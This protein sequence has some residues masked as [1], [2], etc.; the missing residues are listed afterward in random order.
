MVPKCLRTGNVQR[1]GELM[2]LSHDGDRVTRLVDGRRMPTDNGYPDE[3][4]DALIGDLESGDPSRIE[5]ARLWRRPG[6]YNVSLPEV[7][8]LVDIALATP[9]V[10]GAGLVGAGMG[11]CIV[12]IVRSEQ[13]QTLIENLT[14]QYYDARRLAPKAEVIKPVGGLHTF[15]L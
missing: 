12:A 8:E 14:R 1:F 2:N 4:I 5:K 11:G 9:G 7:D 10:M 6:G 15:S 3:R 13:A